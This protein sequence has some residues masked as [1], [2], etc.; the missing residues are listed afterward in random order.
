MA[1]FRIAFGIV[2]PDPAGRIDHG[3]RPNAIKCPGDRVSVAKLDLVP[4]DEHMPEV[5]VRACARK[6]TPQGAC[7]AHDQK[8]RGFRLGCAA[9]MRKQRRRSRD[10]RIKQAV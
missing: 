1:S 9:A 8:Q 10:G 5:A 7:R 3:P 6:R 4:A 2:Y